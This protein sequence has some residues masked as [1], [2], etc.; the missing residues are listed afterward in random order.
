M[1][2]NNES[3]KFHISK[4]TNKKLSIQIPAIFTRGDEGKVHII[5][6]LSV[7]FHVTFHDLCCKETPKVQSSVLCHILYLYKLQVA[8]SSSRYSQVY[9]QD[10]INELNI[11]KMNLLIVP[12]TVVKFKLAFLR[13]QWAVNILPELP[14]IWSD[15]KSLNGLNLLE[16]IYIKFRETELVEIS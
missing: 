15:W 6:L 11:W 5:H 2:T 12:V 1:Q 4:G 13:A 3:F 16:D 10:S 7:R 8:I 14:F 9:P